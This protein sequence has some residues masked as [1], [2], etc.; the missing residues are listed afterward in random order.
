MPSAGTLTVA[1]RGVDERQLFRCDARLGRPR[2]SWY[3]RKGT[4]AYAGA[5]A[6]CPLAQP[7]PRADGIGFNRDADAVN[8]IGGYWV[9]GNAE[10]VLHTK[11]GSSVYLAGEGSRTGM[12]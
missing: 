9:C 10:R 5:A 12:V 1:A 2:R 11:L 6:I 7:M 4:N 8:I 3:L